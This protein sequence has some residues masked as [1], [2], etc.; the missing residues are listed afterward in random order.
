MQ[1]SVSQPLASKLQPYFLR[2]HSSITKDFSH[3]K[4]FESFFEKNS[5]NLL[6]VDT[7]EIILKEWSV[8][9]TFGASLFL[10]TGDDNLPFA[11]YL[12]GNGVLGEF[13]RR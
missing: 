10:L 3:C 8:V 12:L 1:P 2:H 7:I 6:E 13:Q 9:A 11:R 5:I 4:G